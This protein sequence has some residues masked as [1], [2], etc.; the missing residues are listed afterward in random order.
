MDKILW[1]CVGGIGESGPEDTS[2]T[3]RGM[4]KSVTDHLNPVKFDSEWVPWID[5]YGPVPS[6]NGKSYREAIAIGENE[7]NAK[8]DSIP[9]SQKIGILGYSAGA[10][11]AGNV[12]TMNPRVVACA[13][14][15]D[16]VRQIMHWPDGYGILGQR[17]VKQ[18]WLW[19]VANPYDYITACPAGSPLRS[20]PDLTQGFSVTDP[21]AWGRTL[22]L[23]T[24]QAW[25]NNPFIDWS[26]VAAGLAGYL[27]P[28][29]WGQH[30][31]YDHMI[32]PG[33][34]MFYT[35]WLANELNNWDRWN[36]V[37]PT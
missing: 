34:T 15:S 36:D 1:L 24:L 17:P 26:S 7:L 6:W 5:Q 8:I 21:L 20:I 37:A 29:P 4:L 25:W 3:P 28:Y 16:P 32:M 33:T 35:D 13:L 12:A 22:N 30:T 14:V 2:T 31:G 10:H 23:R 11:I 9:L 27:S 19:Q 18:C